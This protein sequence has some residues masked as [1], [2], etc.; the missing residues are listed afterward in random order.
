MTMLVNGERRFQRPAGSGGPFT[1]GLPDRIRATDMASKRRAA[2]KP[3][4]AGSSGDAGAFDALRAPPGWIY[5]V[6]RDSAATRGAGGRTLQES[7]E[8]IRARAGY[9]S[10][11]VQAY[12]YHL[13]HTAIDQYASTTCGGCL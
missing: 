9:P 11:E 8:L 1:A 5:R 6:S 12:L 4:A 7:D 2:M 3:S 10:S 13:A